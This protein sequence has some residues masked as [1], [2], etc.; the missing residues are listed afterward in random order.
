[1]PGFV[2]HQGVPGPVPRPVTFVTEESDVSLLTL[3]PIDLVPGGGAPTDLTAALA[4]S[5]LGSNTG[6]LFPNT[7][8]EVVYIQTNA[9]SGG[10]TVSSDIGAT[11]QGQAVPAKQPPSPQ[12]A[13]KIL[14]Y[15]PYP[16]QYNKPDGSGHV[17]IDIGTPANVTGIVVV[18]QGGVF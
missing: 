3:D 13:S 18:R 7:G 1:M 2:F 4:A 16:S 9:T 14:M 8:H 11:I 5:L 10:S 12:A 17:Q 6:I 15:G